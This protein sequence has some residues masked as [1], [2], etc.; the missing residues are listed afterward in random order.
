M[1]AGFC[2]IG[3]ERKV[4]TERGGGG[5]TGREGKKEMNLKRLTNDAQE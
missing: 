3:E 1:L 2:G 5:N 4:G